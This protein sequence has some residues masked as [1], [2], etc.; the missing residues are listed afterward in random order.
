MAVLK[1]S[2]DVEWTVP[3]AASSDLHDRRLVQQHE[4]GASSPPV[5]SDEGHPA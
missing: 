5:L 1:V 3:E 4:V 2:C